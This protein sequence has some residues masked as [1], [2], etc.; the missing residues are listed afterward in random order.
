MDEEYIFVDLSTYAAIWLT[1]G[2]TRNFL[3]FKRF[4]HKEFVSQTF[5]KN[6]WAEFHQVCRSTGSSE[7]PHHLTRC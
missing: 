6:K 1:I 3:Y 7:L 5:F 2:A 4:L